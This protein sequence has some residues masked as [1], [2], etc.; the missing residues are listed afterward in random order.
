MK[1]FSFKKIDAFTQGKSSGNPC[2]C[3]YLNSV[4]DISPEE[5]QRIAGELR[6]FVNEVVYL[7]PEESAF[8]LKYYSAECEVDFCGHG[9]IGIM[10]DYIVSHPDLLSQEI[11]HIRV[12]DEILDVYNKIKDQAC[13]YI[14]APS[15]TFDSVGLKTKEIA[16][17]L[18][19]NPEDIGDQF[20]PALINA[21]LNTLIVPVAGLDQCL[22]VRPDQ[23][24]LRDFCLYN[25]LDIIL[26]FTSDVAGRDHKF[27]TRVFAPKFGYLEDPATGSGNSAFG[28]YLLKKDLWN[29]SGI[30]IEQNNSRRCPNIIKLDTVKQGS[31]TRVIFGGAA[32]VKITGV[33][34][35]TETS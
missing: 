29:G 34:T 17:V 26:V 5:M 25:G 6:G 21:G 12:K 15:P 13:V 20:E 8:R 4:A 18:N 3:V 14:R 35:L 24:T 19:M 16:A 31:D 11:V 1:T 30:S 33:Y 2:A 23:K 10:Y 7:F 9:T 22:S 28:Y 32:L 27:R